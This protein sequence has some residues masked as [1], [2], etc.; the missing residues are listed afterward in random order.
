VWSQP[1]F[2]ENQ[3]VRKTK[4]V[5]AETGIS[6][7]DFE[8]M[9]IHRRK[10]RQERR[11]PT[12]TWAVNDEQL[13]AVMLRFAE[14]RLYIKD[15]AGTDA[16]R[17][18]RIQAESARVLPQKRKD[19]EHR[20]AIYAKL[21]E[22][23]EKVA[24]RFAIQVQNM[25]TEILVLERGVVTLAS[26]IVYQ[27]Y[28]QGLNSVEVAQELGLRS[29]M[30]RIWLYRLHATANRVFGGG[31]THDSGKKLKDG[32]W[33]LGSNSVVAVW[34]QK[35]LLA[36]FAMRTNG[37]SFAVCARTLGEPSRATRIA[38]RYHFGD[39]KVRH[40][41]ADKVKVPTS[42]LRDHERGTRLRD[43]FALR[44]A[45]K[46][47][48]Q[49]A[50]QLKMNDQYVRKFWRQYFGDLKVAPAKDEDEAARASTPSACLD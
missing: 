3:F 43:L 10:V 20:L 39:L 50:A 18:S 7:Q 29:P 14:D 23:N 28:R 12:P 24:S 19:L 35:K 2:D 17:L 26:A 31:R 32:R 38:W 8:G 42:S 9:H 47:W 16:E 33:R 21:T 11:L 13:R 45:G 44:A 5:T 22:Q 4:A 48:D 6:F 46:T 37:A 25:D 1:K 15:H 27:Y 40:V 34:E 49:C 36:L 41:A 30:I